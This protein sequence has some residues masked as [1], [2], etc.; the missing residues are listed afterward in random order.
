MVPIPV[1]RALRKLGQD[2]RDARLRRCIPT[3]VMAERASISRTTLTK[4]ASWLA[5]AN[6]F[7]LEPALTLGPGPFH[8]TSGRPLFGT[9]GD[10]APDRWARL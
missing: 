5:Y 2:V 3:A 6:R 8:T 7:A 9:I 10:S 1:R 4:D